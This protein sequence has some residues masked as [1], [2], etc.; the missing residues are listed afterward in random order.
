MDYFGLYALAASHR[1]SLSNLARTLNSAANFPWY[2]WILITQF[3][4]YQCQTNLFHFL[5]V[6]VFMVNFSD[7]QTSAPLKT[8]ARSLKNCSVLPYKSIVDDLAHVGVV[9]HE[10]NSWGRVMFVLC[11]SGPVFNALLSLPFT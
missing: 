6:M 4:Y 9:Y 3:C 11:F 7:F 2:H 8:S 1:G 5:D 10:I